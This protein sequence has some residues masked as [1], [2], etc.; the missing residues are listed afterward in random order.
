M[1]RCNQNF[2]IGIGRKPMP[3]LFQ[4]TSEFDEVIDFAI[5]RNP[6][7]V[8]KVHGLFSGVAQVEN[9]QSAVAKSDR[10]A[11]VDAGTI[12]STMRQSIDER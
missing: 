12:R 1:V 2:R 4:L 7:T 8:A 5:E 3:K 11:G 6:V 9:S 10:T